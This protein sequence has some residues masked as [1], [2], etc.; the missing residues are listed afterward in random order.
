MFFVKFVK[1][2]RLSF[3]QKTVG[4]LLPISSNNSDISLALT[5]INLLTLF[6]GPSQ[7]AARKQFT[8]FVSRIFKITKVEG[9][10]FCG[11]VR[12]N[13]RKRAFSRSKSVLQKQRSEIFG[14]A[15]RK[16]PVKEFFFSL[17][18]R[19]FTDFT[20]FF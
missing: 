13:E 19:N 16:T 4:R 17:K 5:T 1:F 2:Y 12:R 14:K 18:V 9:N 6:L 11:W 3:L 15:H 7:W 8:V 10:I 20:D